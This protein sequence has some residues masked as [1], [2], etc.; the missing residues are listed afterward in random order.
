M[1]SGSTPFA[2]PYR[3]IETV[4]TVVQVGMVLLTLLYS[5]NTDALV[6][7]AMRVHSVIFCRVFPKQK[8][9]PAGNC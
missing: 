7:L 6:A 4:L 5:V 8:V 9:R 3:I 2:T 1:I